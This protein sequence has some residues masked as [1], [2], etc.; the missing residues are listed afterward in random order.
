MQRGEHKR[1]VKGGGGRGISAGG[2]SGEYNGDVT[3]GRRG[4]VGASSC[5]GA[6]DVETTTGLEYKHNSIGTKYSVSF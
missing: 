6:G 1:A 3:G 5:V 2:N 4:R